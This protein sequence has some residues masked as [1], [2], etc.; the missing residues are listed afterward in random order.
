MKSAMRNIRRT[1]RTHSD[2]Q[3]NA[4]IGEVP[5][6]LAWGSFAG[7]VFE[8]E[9]VS[10][11][12]VPLDWRPFRRQLLSTLPWNPTLVLGDLLAGPRLFQLDHCAPDLRRPAGTA[13]PGNPARLKR[14]SHVLRLVLGCYVGCRWSAFWSGRPLSWHCPRLYDRTRLQ[15]RF[16]NARS[17]TLRRTDAR[18]RA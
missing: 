8:S 5:I 2:G 6:G 9:S 14:W 10:G 16:W 7:V 15:H 3:Q 13:V 4:L 11:C 1:C 18:D 12:L 17:A